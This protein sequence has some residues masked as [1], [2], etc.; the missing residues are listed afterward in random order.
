MKNELN[1]TLGIF[2]KEVSG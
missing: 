1:K 2:Q